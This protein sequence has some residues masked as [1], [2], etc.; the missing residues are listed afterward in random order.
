VTENAECRACFSAISMLSNPAS[1]LSEV[2][3]H[4]EEKVEDGRQVDT[5]VEEEES[6][7]RSTEGKAKDKTD[8]TK[9]KVVD[10]IRMFGILVPPA[11]RSAQSSFREAIDSPV[12]RLAAVTGQLR[13]LERDIGRAR[14]AARKA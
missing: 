14:K 7:D 8:D 9:P 1:R 3:Q 11:L 12:T 4:D 10:P 2:G 13:A 5:G 6:K